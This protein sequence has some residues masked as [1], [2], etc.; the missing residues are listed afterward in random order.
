MSNYP[1]RR[2][3]TELAKLIASLPPESRLPSEPELAKQLGVS[4]ATLREAMRAF[5]NRGLIRRRQGIGT[6]VLPQVP[7][8][9]SG[10]EV[11]ESIE[12]LAR[13]IGL[14]VKMGELQVLQESADEREAALFHLPFGTPL[15][16]VERII[17]AEHRP[18][19]FLIDT[20]PQDILSP[21]EL[22][23]SFTGSVLDLLLRRGKPRLAQSRT[24][25]YAVG[26]TPE[27]ARALQIQRD[28]V[29]LHFEAQ[30]YTDDGQMIDH[31]HS[32]FLPGYFR[33]HVVRRVS[34]T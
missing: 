26:A 23:G 22:N 8:I 19:A 16:R 10:L 32:Y 27:V 11:L 17:Y 25:I 1:F 15:T 34:G 3:Q 18:I 7:V 33:F 13:R 12:T 31:S 30:L 14:S 5:E 6:F 9:E 29:L 28:D 21:S 20:L 2:L 4:R 24:E